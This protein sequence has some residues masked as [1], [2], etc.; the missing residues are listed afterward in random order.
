MGDYSPHSKKGGAD[1]RLLET[2]SIPQ[3]IQKKSRKNF[4]LPKAYKNLE[5][6][7]ILLERNGIIKNS[8]IA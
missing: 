3:K 4:K 7:W 8:L 1:C 6:K 2:I 5:Y